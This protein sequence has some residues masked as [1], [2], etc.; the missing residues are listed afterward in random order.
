MGA[1]RGTYSGG[2]PV[3]GA[4]PVILR[5][6]PRLRAPWPG[7]TRGQT[8]QG[9]PERGRVLS[10]AH[11]GRFLEERGPD[12]SPH[13]LRTRG[14]SRPRGRRTARAAARDPGEKLVPGPGLLPAAWRPRGGLGVGGSGRA[15]SPPPSRERR[16][17]LG[18]KFVTCLRLSRVTSRGRGHL[19]AGEHGGCP[20]RLA[21]GAAQFGSGTV[22]Q[23]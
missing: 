11:R 12:E 1:Q 4:A 3:P 19:D 20:R 13:P 17:L 7:V 14:S 21:E 18:R 9:A 8:P 23:L 2:E 10:V 5:P 16:E 15:P 6:G 22:A